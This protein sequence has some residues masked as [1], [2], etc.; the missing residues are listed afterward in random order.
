MAVLKVLL[1]ILVS[2]A[3]APS[4][5]CIPCLD[6]EGLK[7]KRLVEDTSDCSKYYECTGVTATQLSCPR[8]TSFDPNWNNGD[9]GCKGPDPSLIPD[10]YQDQDQTDRDQSM[11]IVHEVVVFFFRQIRMFHVSGPGPWSEWSDCSR[12]RSRTCH[13]LQDC[14]E[15]EEAPCS[16]KPEDDGKC[17]IKKFD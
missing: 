8:G 4:T 14:K 10:C 1:I 17:F 12:T 9:G 11:Y 7:H 5:A 16:K 13:S 6:F 3:I 15:S 2:G